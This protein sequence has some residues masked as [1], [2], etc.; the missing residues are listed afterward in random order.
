LVQSLLIEQ[1][2]SFNGYLTK[3]LD[4]VLGDT[5]SVR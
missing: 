2:H 1:L 4:S 3:T 5:S